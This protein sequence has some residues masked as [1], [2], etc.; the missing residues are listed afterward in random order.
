MVNKVGITQALLMNLAN[1]DRDAYIKLLPL[2][3]LYAR[4]C[5]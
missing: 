4:T 2:E 1:W 3:M 5:H